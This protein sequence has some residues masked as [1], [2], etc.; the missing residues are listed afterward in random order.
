MKILQA[1]IITIAI[2]LIIIVSPTT[3]STLSFAARTNSATGVGTQHKINN[4]TA[5]SPSPSK[6]TTNP[7]AH[8]ATT[9]LLHVLQRMKI[10]SG[11]S[12][13]TY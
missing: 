13:N 11:S 5:S 9:T 7:V 12:G 10:M 4:S 1:T 6:I 3:Y 8:N 2:V